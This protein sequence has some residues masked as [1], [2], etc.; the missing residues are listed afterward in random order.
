MGS[1][2]QFQIISESEARAVLLLKTDQA[3]V[4]ADKIRANR[5]L[6]PVTTAQELEENRRWLAEQ[7]AGTP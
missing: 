5:R 1:R 7:R 3:E 6:Q 4:Y 2:F